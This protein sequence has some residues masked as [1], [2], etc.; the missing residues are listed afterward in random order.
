MKKVLVTGGA[1]YK[2]C[3]LVP[4]LLD[5]GYSVVVYDLMLFGSQGLP[6]HPNLQV[7]EADIRDIETYKKSVEGVHSVIHMACISNDPSY[8]L[9]PDLSRTINFDCFEPMV[10][11]SKEAGVK[12]FIYV[13][14]SS[15]YGV[16]E[17][18]EVT[19]EHPLVPLTDYNKYKG[20][21]EPL[22]F[23]YQSP[24]FTTVIIRPATVCGYSPRMR[25]DL[26]VNILTNH[27]VNRGLITVFGGSQQRPNIHVDDVTDLYV[28]LLEMPDELI[29]GDIF[30]AGY[31]NHTV[32][33]LAEMVKKV[34]EEEM[35][36]KAPIQIQ[37]TPSNDL[38]SY[39]VSSK[40]IAD[41]LGFVPKRSV[42]DAVRD[43]CK[44]IKAGKFENSMD[45]EAYVNVK[46]VK[47]VG[48]K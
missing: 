21:C 24:D 33:E 18:P 30:N 6:T 10:A 14:S 4:K 35:P 19:E 45:N 2:G 36:E 46:T 20:L 47:K 31:Q 42:E 26:T 17:A 5:A 37:T 15:V 48:L 34:V 22:L 9:D 13:S 41:K 12:R 3:V 38:R 25:F 40:K 44:A 43:V 11:A 1:G 32:S 8:E 29:A 39:H 16:S 27:A 28:Q 23:K 7:V